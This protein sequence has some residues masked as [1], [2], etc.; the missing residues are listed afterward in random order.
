M[1]T[2]F[3][4]HNLH[5]WKCQ[6]GGELSQLQNG[7]KK[8]WNI[9]AKDLGVHIKGLKAKEKEELVAMACWKPEFL[10]WKPAPTSVSLLSVYISNVLVEDVVNKS[11][12]KSILLRQNEKTIETNALL[13]AGAGGIFIDQNFASQGFVIQDLAKPL[14]AFNVD[15]TKNKKGTIK[16]Y[17]DLKL[18]IRNRNTTTQFM[19][20]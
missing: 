8:I 10:K 19:V 16:H 13:D 7:N 1:F 11:I 12:F 6:C 5:I 9:T 17:I 15:G 4:S 18:K 14:E 3:I 20:T 2:W